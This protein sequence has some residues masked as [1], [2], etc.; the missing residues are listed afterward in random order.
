MVSSQPT[1]TEGAATSLE[2]S[3]LSH[4][5]KDPAST[6]ITRS[7]RSSQRRTVYKGF[8]GEIVSTTATAFSY[9][10]NGFISKSGKTVVLLN[11]PF[12]PYKIN[13]QCSRSM[14]S[15]TYS[16]T[17]VHTISTHSLG[18]AWDMRFF[19]SAFTAM[20]GINGL[21]RLQRL[22]SER[23]LSLYSIVDGMSLFHVSI[24]LEGTLIWIM[25]NILQW[26]VLY[27]SPEHAQFLLQ[28]D[29]Q[30][31]FADM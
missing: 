17:T 2:D 3:E 26:A 7:R 6:L 20:S 12:M 25:I 21:T 31:R 13:F 1:P 28:Q 18:G 15:P 24:D 22:F 14:N 27:Q 16:L 4:S 30:H 9:G 5:F 19:S 23:K 10:R 29:L 8:M 11:L